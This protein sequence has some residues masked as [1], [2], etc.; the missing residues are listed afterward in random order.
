MKKLLLV[1]VSSVLLLALAV[2]IFAQEE[3]QENFKQGEVVTLPAGETINR[4]FFAFGERVEISGTVNGDVY[5]AGGIV[6]VDGKINGDLMAAGGM[7]TISGDVSQDVRAAG[8]QVTISGN[9]GQNL[10][11]GGGTVDITDS[12]KIGGSLVAG[13]GNINI[14][15]P[16]GK[17]VRLG[18]GNVTLSSRVGGN[19]DAGVG[20]LRLTSKAVVGGDLT[21]WS[22]KDASIDPAAAISGKVL[23]HFTGQT[24]PSPTKALGILVGINIFLTIISAISTLIL[25]LLIIKF[26]PRPSQS[27]VNK[28]RKKPWQS[29]G[30]GFLTVI[31]TPIVFIILL[32]TVVGI[33]LA[34]ILLALYLVT[35]YTVRIFAMRLIGELLFERFKWK[36]NVYTSFILGLIVYF[37]IQ[38]IPIVGG[39]WTGLVLL[40]ALGA[41]VLTKKDFL[42]NKNT[43]N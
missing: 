31:V 4:D 9:I 42:S 8:G 29:L 10:T 39:I 15:A 1:A 19:I 13:V 12:A 34:L 41:S 40:F 5:T 38:A 17:D 7:L 24:T 32:V 3:K 35:L 16:V 23:K 2:P 25:G 18:G 43:D 14:A 27:V 6:I 20:S 36:A 28:L 37:A 33:P 21:Y 30:V 22:S 11:I 26:L